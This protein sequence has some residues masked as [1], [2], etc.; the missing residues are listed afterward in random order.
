MKQWIRQ[1]PVVVFLVGAF[2]FSWG[3]W[4]L[5]ILSQHNMLPFK[6]PTNWI[7]SFGPLVGALLMLTLAGEKGS[8]R[9]LLRS[10]IAAR[11]GWFWWGF[12]LFGMVLVSILTL[13]IFILM[14]NPL[15]DIHTPGLKHILLFLLYFLVIL[16]LGGPLGEEP[17]WRGVLQPILHKSMTPVI[18]S[19]T[20]GLIW[21]A[22]HF[23][24][25]YLEGA[26]QKDA[27]IVDF[28]LTVIP[29]AFLFTGVY[30]GTKGS[31]LAALVFH[32]SINTYS[33]IIFPAIAPSMKG[34]ALLSNCSTVAL[35]VAAL[36]MV[37]AMR[38][39]FF[40]MQQ[41]LQSVNP[42]P[43]HDARDSSGG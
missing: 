4:T 5:M 27:S 33:E 6:F 8:I 12:C 36:I 25:L 42:T 35:W 26:A 14:G 9:V 15:P 7:G 3:L 2:G 20:I 29:C 11:I 32:S 34:N 31:L 30:L 10:M 22:W 37:G 17:G 1:H 28:G 13:G 24:L 21:T 41:E 16:I 38:R 23:P 19:V 40:G 39:R 18:A 43:T